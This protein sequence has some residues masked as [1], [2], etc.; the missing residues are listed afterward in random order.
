MGAQCQQRVTVGPPPATA[1][2]K[3]A[4]PDESPSSMKHY[5]PEKRSCGC[6]VVGAL[7]VQ[8]K[9]RA[10]WLRACNGVPD[11]VEPGSLARRDA[12]APAARIAASLP[13][14]RAALLKGRSIRVLPPSTGTEA[15]IPLGAQEA[16]DQ[17]H[18]NASRGAASVRTARPRGCGVRRAPR[19]GA[20]DDGG[21][22]H[23]MVALG[24]SIT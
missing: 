19:T 14:R 6:A 7:W 5:V 10:V 23:R 13:L 16:A 12:G 3:R 15:P 21:W 22:M 2:R 8:P 20:L 24:P 1:I 17:A 11:R 18:G 4:V 9:Q